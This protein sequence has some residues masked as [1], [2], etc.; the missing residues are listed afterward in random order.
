[1]NVKPV[2]FLVLSQLSGNPYSGNLWHAIDISQNCQNWNKA[3][4]HLPSNASHVSP[5]VSHDQYCTASAVTLLVAFFGRPGRSSSPMLSLSLL[6][7]AAHFSK[8]YRKGTPSEVYL[9]SLLGFPWGNP[10]LTSVYNAGYDW[11][12]LSLFGKNDTSLN[13]SKCVLCYLICVRPRVTQS[14]IFN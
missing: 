8:C 6:N 7:L 13:R 2:P 5:S 3:Y 11:F 9:W 4:T 14:V 12:Q 1:M 10:F